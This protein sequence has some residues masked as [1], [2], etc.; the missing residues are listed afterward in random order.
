[1]RRDD[2]M[3]NAGVAAALED[4]TY[5][6]PLGVTTMR[7]PVGEGLRFGFSGHQTFPF[8]YGWLKKALDAVDGDPG[9]FRRDDALVVLGV[10]KNM[11]DSIRHWGL[12][13]QMLEDFDRGRVLEPT[14]WGRELFLD[15]A[16]PYLE[17]PASLWLIHWLLVTNPMKAGTWYLAFNHFQ[18]PEFRKETLANFIVGFA[19][20]HEL[21][22][23]P[24]TIERDVDCF[25]RTYTPSRSGDRQVL[26]DSFNCPLVELGALHVLPD[27]VT[28]QFVIGPKPTLPAE[29]VGVVLLHFFAL[30]G[31]HRQTL[32]LQDCLYQPRSPG[33]VFKLDEGALMDYLEELH[34]LTGGAL[35]VDETAGLKQ[36]YRRA[37]IDP[38]SL[39]RGYFREQA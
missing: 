22:A 2:A 28:Y 25:V 33:Q 5:S 27:G 26:E 9:F 31:A 24:R 11:V 29:I 21:R 1:M 18:Y 34:E 4:A 6:R 38:F 37:P 15:G 3:P 19:E 17:D 14:G 32:S 20:R 13:T 36:L 16:D 23:N 8:R 35:T 10:G 7:E 30:T 39:L 12:A